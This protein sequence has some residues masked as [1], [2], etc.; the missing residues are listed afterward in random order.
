[1]IKEY[2]VFFN[3]KT[4]RLIDLFKKTIVENDIKE[5]CIASAF[6]AFDKQ[7]RELLE[8]LNIKNILTKVIVGSAPYNLIRKDATLL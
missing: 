1:M 6:F 5:V 4:L 2:L 7:M 3:N 8:L